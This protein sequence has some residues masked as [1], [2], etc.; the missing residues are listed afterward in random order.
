[1][2]EVP[3]SMRARTLPYRRG[4]GHK[5]APANGVP[6]VSLAGGTSL[7]L[8][9]I[10][11][12]LIFYQNLP[13]N[14]GL[15]AAQSQVSDITTN[16]A[17]ATNTADGPTGNTL[18]RII[19]V[20]TI[21]MSAYFVIA[22]WPLARS[23]A[24]NINV[25]A[26]AFLG[27]A[28]LSAKWS[29]D[30]PETVFRCISLGSITLVCFA[31]ALAG[32]DRRRF[33]QL[34]T[35]P[36][37]FIVVASL[38]LGI[39]F[40]DEIREFGDDLSLK[41]AWHGITMT[42][43]QLGMAS[44]LGAIICVHRLLV[45][46][47]R[48]FWA[49]AGAATA[50]A[51]LMLSRSN[52]S[53]FATLAGVI[54]MVAALRIPMIK[55]R[56]TTHVVIAIAATLLIY[57]LVIQDLFPGAHTLLGPIRDLTGKDATFSARTNI[58][59]I[60]KDH[61]RTAPY[62]GTGYGAYWVGPYPTS[63]S[64]VF[65]YF[66]FFYPTEAHNGYLDVANDLGYAGLICVLVFLIS[67]V[68]QGLRLMQIDRAQAVLY[69]AILFQQMVLNMSESEWFARDSVFT[70]VLLAITCMARALRESRQQPQSAPQQDLSH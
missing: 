53:Q 7:V 62:L 52:T 33:Q 30:R 49:I 23:V 18:D 10:F 50:F 28:L 40:P 2:R 67:Y 38:V 31:I 55:R 42:K 8:L 48:T 17:D 1:M 6:A 59:E 60:V 41:G 13:S 46:E 37:M 45:R 19:K 4:T 58:W 9:S 57:E 61:M 21:L 51:C 12:W 63:P 27:L 36:L 69:L 29:I 68:R 15:Y 16:A 34:A 24:K 11:F 3:E 43:N 22:R 25:G 14:L 70:V 39:I 20:C 65:T 5:V 44:S 35:P 54:F 26:A 56:Y 66:M 64:F 47:G 32:W